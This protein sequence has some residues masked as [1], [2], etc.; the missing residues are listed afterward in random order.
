M[1]QLLERETAGLIHLGGNPHQRLLLAAAGEVAVD[2][3][4]AKVGYAADDP[5]RE[6]RLGI[7]EDLAER[8]VP[9]HELRLL[10]PEAL[11]IRDR[12]AVKVPVAR[13]RPSVADGSVFFAGL[14]RLGNVLQP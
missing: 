10:G 9:V 3:V 1:E 8:L 14:D 7:V 5:A 12:A 11:A 4:M 6:R 13:H 2:G